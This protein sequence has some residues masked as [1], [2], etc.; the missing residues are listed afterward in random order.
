MD[1][2]Q[3]VIINQAKDAYAR[4]R[5]DS[6]SVE[7]RQRYEFVFN[8]C[9][10]LAVL[11]KCAPKLIPKPNTDG[12]IEYLDCSFIY[13]DSKIY[14]SYECSSCTNRHEF[15][16]NDLAD[17]GNFIHERNEIILNCPPAPEVPDPRTELDILRAI[18]TEIQQL[19]SESS[20]R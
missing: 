14:I 8:F 16:I 20:S 4:R 10:S 19:K 1:D 12:V 3:R 15:P 9:K 6:I 11:L 2:I 18:L 13:R 7:E 5:I 17:L